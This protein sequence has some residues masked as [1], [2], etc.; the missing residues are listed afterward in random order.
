MMMTL[1]RLARLL[2]NG[3]V[4]R[5]ASA[6]AQRRAERKPSKLGRR[7]RRKHLAGRAGAF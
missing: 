3:D 1:R 5:L 6:L 2:D 4:V 7:L